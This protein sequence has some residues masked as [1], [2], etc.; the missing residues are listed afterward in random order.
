MEGD[1]YTQE[2]IT[3]IR[4][5]SLTNNTEENLKL[6]RRICVLINGQSKNEHNSFKWD[7]SISSNKQDF[8]LKSQYIHSGSAIFLLIKYSHLRPNDSFVDTI[9]KSGITEEC[10]KIATDVLSVDPDCND[11]LI[12]YDK[13]FN[14]DNK[15]T[16]VDE[17]NNK[18]I[19]Y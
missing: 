17:C 18:T 5:L 15:M 16:I 1:R 7:R 6:K 3:K 14:P 8:V 9:I 10:L 11:F 12:N 4:S 13:I 19:S 2:I